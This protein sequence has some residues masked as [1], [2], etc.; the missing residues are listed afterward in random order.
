MRLFI[1][2]TIPPHIKNVLYKA[3][4]QIQNTIN[5]G[6]FTS[7]HNYHITLV[8]I[9]EL[10]KSIIPT[11]E[12]IIKDISQQFP[13]IFL[14]STYV[15]CFEKKNKKILYFG[16]DGALNILQKLNQLISERLI[17]K[18]FCEK[19]DVFIPHITFARSVK[20][21]NINRIKKVVDF[22]SSEIALMHSTRIN[23]KLVYI[24][25]YSS[26]LNSCYT[27]DRIEEDT[28]VCEHKNE[29]FNMDTHYLPDQAK[30]GNK[31]YYDGHNFRVDESQSQSNI[32]RI[33]NKFE[34]L[35]G[36]HKCN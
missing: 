2:L 5:N 12:A 30:P 17:E 15:D 4:E 1:A 31:I 28:V 10:S 23:N 14:K 11:I 6:N 18:T 35:K 34:K 32:N 8:F 9:G 24:P 21:D 22:F 7:L 36:E 19:Q 13:P 33:Q 20:C 29:I 3:S 25:I 26:L 16:I 27:I